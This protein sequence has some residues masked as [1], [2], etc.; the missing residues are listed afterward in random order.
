MTPALGAADV[1]VFRAAQPIDRLSDVAKTIQ[2]LAIETWGEQRAVVLV[3][4]DPA[5]EDVQRRLAQ[6]ARAESPVLI[7]GE[8]GTGKELFARA[9][10]LLSGRRVHPYLAVNCAQYQDGNLLVSEL[11]GHR[12]GSFTGAISDRRGVFEEADRGTVFLDEIAELSPAAQGMLLRA[13]G[14]GEVL[15][16]GESR[17]H[18][19]DVRVIA[20]TSRQLEAMVSDGR[21]RSDLYFRLRFLRLDLPPVRA[22]GDDI[23]RLADYHL[24]A[25]NRAYGA[26]KRLSPAARDRLHSYAWPGN[27]SELNGIVELAFFSCGSNSIEPEHFEAELSRATAPGAPPPAGSDSTAGA[28]R[29]RT[30]APLRCL[31]QLRS[32]GSFWDVVH[33]PYMDRDLNRSEVTTLIAM[34]LD[35]TGGSYKQLLPFFGIHPDHYV[36]FMDFLRHHRL[37]PRGPLPRV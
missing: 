29:E 26:A 4:R 20:A 18:R 36:R 28:P 33:A 12:R 11:F 37:K 27:I 17:P 19:V 7:T 15:R 24:E 16:L 31:A 3:G 13:I 9:L 14:E 10:L 1:R 30:G 22:R 21:F 34:G 25:L 35:E 2:R 6:F 32:G 8:T 23:D 5:I